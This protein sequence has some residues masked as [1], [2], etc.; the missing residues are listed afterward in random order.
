MFFTIF[1]DCTF[2]IKLFILFL[3]TILIKNKGGDIALFH[4]VK[5]YLFIFIIVGAIIIGVFLTR[6]DQG[7]IEEE[8]KVPVTQLEVTKENNPVEVVAPEN[9]K[10]IV[11]VKGEVKRAGVYEINSNSRV[12]DVIN[13]AGGF[14]E[15]ADQTQINLAQKVE[16]EMVIHVV[17]EG[18]E[19]AQPLVNSTDTS[20]QQGVKVNYATVEELA[21]LNGIGPSKAAAIIAYRDEHGLFQTVEDLL[22]V[23]G[24]GEKTL[25]NLKDSIILP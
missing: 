22:E 5:K 15:E 23:N 7:K 10:V 1:T 9:E 25:E 24:I 4:F 17:K 3:H 20:Q 8:N 18:D 6:N 16:D 2:T 21:T 13:L 11:D 19:P 14:T 12:N